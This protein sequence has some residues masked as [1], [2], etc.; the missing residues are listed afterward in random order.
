MM[1]SKTQKEI[2]TMDHDEID[3]DDIA[4][5]FDRYRRRPRDVVKKTPYTGSNRDLAALDGQTV[6]VIQ[7]MLGEHGITEVR[8]RE[9]ITRPVVLEGA[10]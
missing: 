3:I 7:Y 5:L 4:E 2:T 1:N 10:A 9:T 6:E 8:T